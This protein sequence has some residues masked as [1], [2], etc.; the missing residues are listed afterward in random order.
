MQV[1][2]VLWRRGGL[3]TQSQGSLSCFQETSL[4]PPPRILIFSKVWARFHHS[5]SLL[6]E[7]ADFLHEGAD[8]LEEGAN[9]LQEVLYFYRK[10]PIEVRDGPEFIVWGDL[11]TKDRFGCMQATI[12]TLTHCCH[13]FLPPLS[14]CNE[15]TCTIKADHWVIKRK[16][17]LNEK[18]HW[19][20]IP[21]PSQLSKSSVSAIVRPLSSSCSMHPRRKNC[22]RTSCR[23]PVA[24][25]PTRVYTIQSPEA[26]N[27][28]AGTCS[29]VTSFTVSNL[30]RGT[31]GPVQLSS[32]KQ[33]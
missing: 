22:Y 9:F 23:S 5:L 1:A 2:G 14:T 30:R 17:F 24:V 15:V 26:C 16:R 31:S 7:D 20:A 19:D 18:I 4:A 33:I 11:T 32:I 13:L 6:Q 12:V 28:N 21:Y 8:F 25:K 3:S 27:N 29:W 10:L